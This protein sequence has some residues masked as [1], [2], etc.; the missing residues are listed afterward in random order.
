MFGFLP[1]E[2]AAPAVASAPTAFKVSSAATT[3]LWM[4]VWWF[5]CHEIL[6]QLNNYVWKEACS[7]YLLLQ[8]ILQ[9]IPLLCKAACRQG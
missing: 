8:W 7:Q 2:K 5:D 6:M 4:Q 3:N 9:A 1:E